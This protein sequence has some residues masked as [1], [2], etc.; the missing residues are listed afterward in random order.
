M[1]AA[2]KGKIMQGRKI[3]V[4]IA[5]PELDGHDRGAKVVCL[6]LRDA[7]MDV[8]YSGL[9]RSIDDIVTIALE[10]SVD[11]LGLSI[12]TGAHLPICERLMQRLREEGLIDTHLVVGGVIPKRDIARLEKIG[13]RGVFPGGTRFDV[14]VDSIRALF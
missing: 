5:K 9:H 4:L 1:R 2:G 13:A 11:V 7:G 14:I 6:A 12:M 8:I 3:R 10:E